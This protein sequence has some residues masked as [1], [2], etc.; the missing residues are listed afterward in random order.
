VGC[1]NRILECFGILSFL[2]DVDRSREFW[3]DGQ[4]LVSAVLDWISDS[5]FTEY[6]EEY[7]IKYSSA[8]DFRQRHIINQ[9]K[10]NRFY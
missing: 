4:H 5:G 6:F 9:L 1:V 2:A 3:R 10:S 7:D 8:Q